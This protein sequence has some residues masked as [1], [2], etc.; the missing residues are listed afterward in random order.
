VPRADRVR[1]ISTV[2]PQAV[3][4]TLD[5]VTSDPLKG[6]ALITGRSAAS[7]V[8]TILSLPLSFT[9]HMTVIGATISTRAANGVRTVLLY[10]RG[11]AWSLRV[12]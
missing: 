12:V 5:S 3:V 4:G 7:H 6:T 1:R 11:G 10:A 8:P 9:G 2:Y